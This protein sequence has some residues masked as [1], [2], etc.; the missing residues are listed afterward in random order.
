MRSYLNGI[1]PNLG[2]IVLLD[3][4]IVATATE[5]NNQYYKTKKL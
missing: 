5:K 1:G 2:L 4:L 3:I